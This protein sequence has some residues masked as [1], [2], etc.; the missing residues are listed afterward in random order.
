[1]TV[2]K[3][4]STIHIPVKMVHTN[5]GRVTGTIGHGSTSAGAF[6]VPVGMTAG[7]PSVRGKV[8]TMGTPFFKPKGNTEPILIFLSYDKDAAH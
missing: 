5:D 4:G 3:V 7:Q 8:L 6:N 2:T 1:M